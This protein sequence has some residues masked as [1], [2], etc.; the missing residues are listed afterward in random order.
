MEEL[1]HLDEKFTLDQWDALFGRD[2]P[3]GT[4]DSDKLT[5]FN[6]T[7]M[8]PKAVWDKLHSAGQDSNHLD[9]TDIEY[10]IKNPDKIDPQIQ[11][12]LIA[13]SR[14]GGGGNEDKYNNI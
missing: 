12:R 8:S 4:I 11:S 7:N 5:K 13:V 3:I 1:G 6:D 10:Y 9:I 2:K 14:A